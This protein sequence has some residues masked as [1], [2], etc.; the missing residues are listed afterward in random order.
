M[1]AESSLAVRVCYFFSNPT[2]VQHMYLDENLYGLDVLLKVHIEH[3][4]HHAF[5]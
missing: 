4:V 5:T 1:D 2:F 3:H